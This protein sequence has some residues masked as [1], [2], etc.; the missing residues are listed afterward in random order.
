MAKSQAGAQTMQSGFDRPQVVGVVVGRAL[1]AGS[2]YLHE[3]WGL[4]GLL[5]ACRVATTQ[6]ICPHWQLKT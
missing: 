4:A 2:R 1:V 6:F 5:V 3:S